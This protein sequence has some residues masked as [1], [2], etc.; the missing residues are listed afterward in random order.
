MT[1]ESIRVGTLFG[2]VGRPARSCQDADLGHVHDGVCR[3]IHA[4]DTFPGFAAGPAAVCDTLG[5]CAFPRNT[6]LHRPARFRSAACDLVQGIQNR[7]LLHA[8]TALEQGGKTTAPVSSLPGGSTTPSSHHTSPAPSPSTLCPNGHVPPQQM[9]LQGTSFSPPF[10]V[11]KKPRGWGCMP[12]AAWINWS[13][14]VAGLRSWSRV[15]CSIITALGALMM[16]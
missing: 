14:Q 2:G 6:L 15:C 3:P 7:R 5:T 12:P 10:A 11:N 13:R 1:V 4:A 16:S 8:R 9:S